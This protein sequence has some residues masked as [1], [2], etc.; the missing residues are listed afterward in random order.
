M[1]STTTWTP[2]Q[3]YG[4]ANVDK[5]ALDRQ[6]PCKGRNLPIAP[7]QIRWP[8]YPQGPQVSTLLL[9]IAKPLFLSPQK[10]EGISTFNE[11]LLQVFPICCYSSAV[12]TGKRAFRRRVPSQTAVW[13]EPSPPG[14][15]ARLGIGTPRRWHPLSSGPTSAWRQPSLSADLRSRQRAGQSFWSYGCGPRICAT[16]LRDTA[17][18]G[19]ICLL[20]GQCLQVHHLIVEGHGGNLGHVSRPGSQDNV[21]VVRPEHKALFAHR[22]CLEV[23][24]P[25]DGI[26]R[27]QERCLSRYKLDWLQQFNGTPLQSSQDNREIPGGHQGWPRRMQ[28]P[29][30]PQEPHDEIVLSQGPA[31]HCIMMHCDSSHIRFEGGGWQPTLQPFLQEKSTTPIVHLQGSSQWEEHQIANRLHSKTRAC[32]VER[33]LAWVKVSS[34]AS[35]QNT[36]VCRVS[37]RNHTWRFQDLDAGARWCRAPEKGG[38]SSEGCARRGCHEEHEFRKPGLGGPNGVTG[39]TC[40]SSLL[41]LH[42]VCAR[43]LTGGS[44]NLRKTQGQ[45]C[46][47]ASMPRGPRSGSHTTGRGRTHG[48]Q[49]GLPELPR[50]DSRTAGSSWDGVAILQ[51]TWAVVRAHRLY[52]W[53]P[54]GCGQRLALRLTPEEEMAGELWHAMWS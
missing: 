15:T 49:P 7:A 25:L 10:L 43:R 16:L 34:T 51:G 39:R 32:L 24:D 14:G 18:Q 54:P 2:S 48:R 35:A 8:W 53:G 3:P 37:S 21:R 22:K 33:A 47:S 6:M 31:V 40:S 46:A 52:D 5:Q 20:R 50:I 13:S 11:R 38:P 29:G 28:A 41:T 9:E 26:E 45:L 42:S 44:A 19:W 27:G 30:T 36:Q 1:E 17:R 23:P 4:I 12:T